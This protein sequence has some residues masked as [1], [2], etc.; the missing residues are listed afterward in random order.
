M[1]RSALEQTDKFEGSPEEKKVAFF[2]GQLGIKYEVLTTDELVTL[3]GSLRKSKF[4]AAPGIR[5][6]KGRRKKK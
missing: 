2:L 4:M 6:S 5:R 3:M 1:I